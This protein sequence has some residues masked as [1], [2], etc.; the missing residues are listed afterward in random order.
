MSAAEVQATADWL[1]ALTRD[2]GLPPKIFI[3]HQFRIDM[4]PD[5]H[6]FVPPAELDAVIQMDGLGSQAQK[7]QTWNVLNGYGAAERF[8]WGWKNFYEDD[9]PLAS[10]QKVEGLVP[11]AVYVSYQ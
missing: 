8:W 2:N 1:A 7:D 6:L 9:V 10:P 4:F 11:S 3:V 5:R